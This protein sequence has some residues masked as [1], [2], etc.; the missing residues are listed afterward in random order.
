MVRGM[1]FVTSDQLVED[2]AADRFPAILSSWAST[3]ARV[4]LLS[5]PNV[6]MMKEIFCG[7]VT[8]YVSAGKRVPLW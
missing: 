6:P 8:I 2:H 5:L 4:I 1:I 3:S 7:N